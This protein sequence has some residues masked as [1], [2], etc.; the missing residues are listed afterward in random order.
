MEKRNK[1]TIKMQKKL[2]VLFGL[3]LLAFAGLSARLILINKDN[4]EQYKKQVLSQQQYSSTTIPYKRGEIL[5]SKGT[6]LAASEKVYDLVLDVKA[7]NNKEDYVEPTIQALSDYFDVDT[8]KV[9]E[10]VQ[11]HP[12]SQYY[13]LKKRMSYDEISDYQAMM[14]DENQKETSQYIKGIWFDE[15]Y[16]RVYPN[17]SLASDVIG[18][19]RTDGTGTYGL[20]EY[21]D[22]VLSGVNG[23][24]YGYMDSDEN[25]QRTTEP[26]VDGYN[27]Y[28]TIDATIQGI[29]EKYLK[30]YNDENKNVAREGNGAQDISAIVMDVDS[31][32]V[33]AMASYPFFNLNDTRDTSALIGSRLI[34]VSG[35][36]T[37]TVINEEIAASLEEKDKNDLLVQNLNALW[38]N[39]C[40]N[41]TYEPGSTMKPFVAAMGLEDGRLKG[42]ESFECTGIVEIGGYKIRC[43][44]Y[45]TSGAE[46]WLTIDQAI[47]RSC[48]IALIKM[49][50]VI[51]NDEFLKY[52]EEFNFGLKTNIDLAGEARTASLVFNSN[53]LGPT[54]LATSSFGQGFNVTMIQ[55]ITGFC[56][57]ING[58]Y[59]YEPHMVSKITASDGSVVENIEPRL[60]KQTVSAETSAKIR[61]Y[62]V[63]V[64]E[65]ENGTGKRARPAG[66]RIG[67][68]T[69]TAETVSAQGTREK[70]EYVVSFLGYAPADDPQIAI[71][72]V[73]NRPN[74]RN[75]DLET[76]KACIIAK[77]IL[78]EVLPYLNIFMTEPLTEEEEK[79]LE[80]MQIDIRQQLSAGVSGNDVSGN[81]A[82]TGTGAETGTG[83]GD[84]DS[85][86]AAGGDAA[87][88]QEG[89]QTQESNPYVNADG[90]L[91]DPDTGEKITEDTPGYDLPVSGLLNG[92][93]AG[94]AGARD[95]PPSGLS[96]T[97]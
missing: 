46:G 71:Y 18:F 50:Q 67:G 51:G 7:M 90:E 86:E 80:E 33:L 22:S 56:S 96:F 6:K 17:D 55:M 15:S 62:C 2:V 58:G 14:A 54:E 41:S 34:D 26:A 25:L 89:E 72:V 28:S 37:T 21:Y 49:A 3:V 4:G 35:N 95:E 44:N 61:D 32:E 5:D 78:T 30:K 70:D 97:P 85:G 12:D 47:E 9:R 20:E 42:N 53:T 76:R 88:G 91:V 52:M 13:V 81:E 40:I 82:G 60:L 19:T 36:T 92:S 43:H 83:T 29:V 93:D 16:K 31:G 27:I 48:N 84:P 68:K 38:K 39:Y 57:L 75:Q 79:E 66:Y 24:T 87:A 64:V 11:E 59:Y 63:Q 10:Y 77:N 73:L 23:R 45:S 65:G 74:A 94:E 8:G 69:G 1:F